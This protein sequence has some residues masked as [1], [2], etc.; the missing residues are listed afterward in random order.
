M[1]RLTIISLFLIALAAGFSAMANKSSSQ[2]SFKEHAESR[3]NISRALSSEIKKNS[4]PAN[5][6][7]NINDDKEN[8]K[9][10]YTLDKKLQKQANDLLQRYKPDYGAIF[11]INAETG[12]VL[13][14]ASQQ[15]G[16]P[17]GENLNLKASFP[18]ASVFKVVTATA[19][20]D[21]AKVDPRHRI[22]FNGGNYTLYKS[23]V[24]SDKI[25]RWTR[26]ITLKDAF[27]RSINTAFGRLT[28]ENLNPAVIAEY[29][30]KFMFNE[31]LGADF[32]VEQSQAII[33]KEKGFEL[34]QVASGYNRQNTMSPVHGA[35]IASAIINDGKMV[36]P[37]IVE[38]V[39]NDKNE[40]I[41]SGKSTFNTPVMSKNSALKIK[42]MME[43]TVLT[44]T[45]RK[46]FRQMVRDKKFKEI[47]MGGKTG[48]FSGSNPRGTTDWFIGYA[49][50]G[51]KKI[52]IATI[53]VNVKKWTV[54]SS[55]L[56]Q[57]MF[58]KYYE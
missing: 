33:P 27:A 47:E 22:A 50:D 21:G 51:D 52:A 45:S 39:K 28:M 13:A 36:T 55:A 37:Y 19:A 9:V 2:E 17:N 7:I 18:A 35:M 30:G 12:E 26:F 32:N 25:N 6:V 23:N 46:T 58:K 1:V 8:Y 29:A 48:H 41:Y 24:L 57:M 38:S 15:K 49:T 14:I 54:K 20:V 43:Q 10:E 34:T 3:R 40:I 53:T 31:D 42:D 4:Y 11:M 56:A 16:N 44:G 5:A